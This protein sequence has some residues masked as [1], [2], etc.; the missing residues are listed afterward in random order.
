MVQFV[1]VAPE[2]IPNLRETHRGRVSYPIIKGFMETGLACVKLDRTGMQQN[3]QYLTSVLGAYIRNHNL[4]IKTFVRQGEMYLLR[5]DLN[6]DGSE[7]PN[8][9]E[10]EQSK[11]GEI[12][13]GVA[14]PINAETVTE[15]FEAEQN[16]TTK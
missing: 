8:W 4:P 14:T 11:S 10:E 7:N 6:A 12:P 13:V 1:E 5:K 15:R 2:D 9:K 3:I 16:L